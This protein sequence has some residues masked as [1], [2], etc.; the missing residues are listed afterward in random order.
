MNFLGPLYY[1]TITADSLN[2]CGG[3]FRA[4]DSNMILP[5]ASYGVS[6]Q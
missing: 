5:V 6:R 3:V 2:D 4:Q 1:Y